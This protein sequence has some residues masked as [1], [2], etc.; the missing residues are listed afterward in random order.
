MYNDDTT[1]LGMRDIFTPEAYLSICGELG[2]E[3]ALLY[4][5]SDG[6]EYMWAK[7]TNELDPKQV[8]VIDDSIV[9]G[10]HYYRLDEFM[11][12]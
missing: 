11:R 5:D 1:K 12:Y 3:I 10:G 4:N 2:I 7:W 8:T 9:L 6:D